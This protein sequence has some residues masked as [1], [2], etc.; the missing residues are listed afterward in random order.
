M[1]K[2]FLSAML[3]LLL[4]L[5]AVAVGGIGAFA[6][7]ED[8]IA[9]GTGG[10]GITWAITKDG[11]MTVSGTGP[12]TDETEIEYYD[13][14]SYSVNT[15]D[16][17]S[18][19]LSSFV[20][21]STE[22]FT[23]EQTERFRYG[24]VRELI[25]EE[26]I[27]AIP[28][29][30]FEG[31]YPRSVSLPASL[32]S[33]GFS[34]IRGEFAE[35]LTVAGNTDINCSIAVSGHTADAEPYKSAE[36]ALEAK[37]ANLV[38]IEEISVKTGVVYDLGLLVEIR[39]GIYTEIT[40]QD[41]LAN[42]NDAYGT[43]FENTDDCAAFLIGKINE[44]LSTE[45]KSADEIFSIEE[46]EE[47]GISYS[48]MDPDAEQ[49]MFDLYEQ[50]SIEDRL[51]PV[52]LTTDGDENYEIYDWLTVYAPEGSGAQKAA[53]SNG[54]PFVAIA[55]PEEEE[56]TSFLVRVKNFFIRLFN[57]IVDFFS[58]LPGFF[59]PQSII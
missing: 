53:D 58:R 56:D 35:K 46:D 1:T 50:N 13:D 18:M 29:N 54:L 17:I 20:D 16:S 37:I 8:I 48:V 38:Q 44:V 11:V 57:K 34:A 21:E 49:K 36:E 30:E 7:G 43:A 42:I 47:A 22:G 33:I 10:E 32:Q 52:T 59:K 12:I 5:G 24:L 23:T 31:V 45:Y 51:T 4:V 27:T 39:A 2:K 28:D 25:I 15:L 19:Q 55:G 41:F 14:D 9:S 6:A 3:S 26:G 40:E